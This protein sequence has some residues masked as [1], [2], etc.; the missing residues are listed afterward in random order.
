VIYTIKGLKYLKLWL[1]IDVF[2]DYDDDDQLLDKEII[3]GSE[4]RG[5][6]EID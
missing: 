3:K 2:I 6:I 4:G 1:Q 5:A